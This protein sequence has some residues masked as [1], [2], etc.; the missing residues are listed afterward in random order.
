M[1]VDIRLSQR[2]FTRMQF[3]IITTILILSVS[4]YSYQDVFGNDYIAR[5]FGAFGLKENS[6]STW[7]SSFNLLLSSIFLFSIYKDSRRCNEYVCRYW[8]MLC[9]LFLLLSLDEVAGFHERASGMRHL[10]GPIWPVLKTH[11]WVLYGTI[12]T[13]II[14]LIFIPFLIRLPRHTAFAFLLAGF[15]FVSGAL[16]IEFI[17]AVMIHTN[18]AHPGDL[19]YNLRRVLEEGCEMYG[20]AIFNCALL[21]EAICRKIYLTIGNEGA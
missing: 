1:S 12:F 21:R 18:F 17:G 2:P 16:G 5:A 9:I 13:V 4:L 3:G 14:F 7:F 10:M 11:H 8:L 15:V 20:I 6:V 19:I